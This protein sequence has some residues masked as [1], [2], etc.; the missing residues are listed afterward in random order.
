MKKIPTAKELIYSLLDDQ[1]DRIALPYNSIDLEAR[2][3]I[4]DIV[5]EMVEGYYTPFEDD[6]E[7]C[8]F[9]KE[10]D[11]NQKL[12]ERIYDIIDEN[13]YAGEGPVFLVGMSAA[14]AVANEV[15][16]ENADLLAAL[17]VAELAMDD[18]HGL[19][20]NDGYG[21]VEKQVVNALVTVRAAILKA[22][23]K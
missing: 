1:E 23:T 19:L 18:T 20:P 3:A 5:Y 8:M 22:E 12:I 7:A 14:S 4:A 21:W 13:A 10:I 6:P 17:K 11:M 16:K 2:K 9:E 15:E